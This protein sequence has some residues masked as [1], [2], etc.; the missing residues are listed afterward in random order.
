MLLKFI[1]R[2][3]QVKNMDDHKKYK[4]ELNKLRYR[5]KKM[6]KVFGDFS[7]YYYPLFGT[8]DVWDARP[9][10]TVDENGYN[11]IIQERREII[12]WKKTRD[13]EEIIYLIFNDL[14]SDIAHETEEYKTKVDLVKD[15]RVVLFNKELELMKLL[16][17]EFYERKKKEIEEILKQYPVITGK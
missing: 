11:Y 13:I 12:S 9:S 10:I 8:V 4:S 7:P 2:N 17:N 3:E 15:S 1:D 16:S 14:V 5:V 6:A